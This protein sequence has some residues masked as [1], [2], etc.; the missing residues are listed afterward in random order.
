MTIRFKIDENVPREA[1]ALLVAA[2]YD[3][4]SVGEENLGGRGDATILSVCM[5]EDRVLVTLDL[6]FADVRA[7]PP[8]IHR[9]IWV[10]R[11]DAQS[12]ER[13][14]SVLR[15]AIG[16]VDDEPIASRL[17]IVEPGRV[18]IRD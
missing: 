15:G 9:G 11:P 14:L 3:T 1:Q 6:D 8:A 2:G 5:K 18:R 13:T 16:L 17:W 12:I 4:H 10:L 7:Y